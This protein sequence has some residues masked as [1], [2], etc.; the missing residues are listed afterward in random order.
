MTTTRHQDRGLFV[1]ERLPYGRVHSLPEPPTTIP[2]ATRTSCSSFPNAKLS[3]TYPWGLH[4]LPSP[5]SFR[6]QKFAFIISCLC[7]PT[8]TSL[9]IIL[10]SDQL[11]IQLHTS[12][13]I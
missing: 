1:V 4:E 11:S 10:P 9:R 5:A 6:I 2:R 8:L 13:H 12:H 3:S 7:I